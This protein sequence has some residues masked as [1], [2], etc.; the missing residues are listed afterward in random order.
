MNVWNSLLRG[1]LLESKRWTPQ[2]W[3][4]THIERLHFRVQNMNRYELI[5]INRL[6]FFSCQLTCLHA[7]FLYYMCI[8]PINLLLH[9]A[10]AI[11]GVGTHLYLWRVKGTRKKTFI[12][13]KKIK[14]RFRWNWYMSWHCSW[15]SLPHGLV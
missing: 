11:G 8:F 9:F 4:Y 15:Q 1:L 3:R 13:L 10:V 14:K 2:L 12:D 7:M 5:N 6:W